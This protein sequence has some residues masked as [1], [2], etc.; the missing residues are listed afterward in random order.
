MLYI[1]G[2]WTES[3]SKKSFTV[4]NPADGQKINKV[5]DGNR[6]DTKKAIEAAATSFPKWSRLTAYERSSFLY[7]AYEIMMNHKEELAQLMTIEQ[8]KPLKFSRNEVQYAADFLL[9]YAEEAKRIYGEVIPSSRRDQRFISIRKPI[10]VVGAIT[11]W[12]YPVSMITRKIA[13]ALAA[14]CTIVLKPAEETPLC[15]ME[16]FKVFDDAG[17]PNGAVNLI[18]TTN[19]EIVGDELINNPAVKKITFTG[20]TEIGKLIAEKAARNVKRVSM[21]LGG[22]APFIVYGDA[23]PVHAAKGAALVKFLNTGQA[24]IS[25]NRIFV[26]RSIAEKFTS[27]LI[28]RVRNLRAGN[29][30]EEGISIG[31]LVNEAAIEKVDGQVKNAVE[32]GATLELGGYRLKENGLD[33]GVFYAPTILSGVHKDM[34]IFREETFGPVAPICIFDNNEEVIE[35]ANDTHYGLAAYVYTKDISKAMRAFEELNFGIIGINDINP[36]SASAPFGG[37]NES[38]LG[39]EGGR[40]G[41]A[42]YLETKLG[43]FSI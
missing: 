41:I 42:E 33:K 4:F 12:N 6:N 9:W 31:P 8:G 43:G 35:M 40:E 25:P 34:R 10:G 18:S 28:D 5:A 36:T 20:S 14:G 26:H 24:C 37:M 23:D 22:H 15:A 32:G 30:L 27:T 7:K 19:A 1:D 3:E 21:E 29:G 2:K 39:R 17:I 38:G 16:V 11:P 13:P